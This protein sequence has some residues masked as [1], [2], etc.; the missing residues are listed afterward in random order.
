MRKT[1][2]TALLETMSLPPDHKHFFRFT[3]PN[4]FFAIAFLLMLGI[5]NGS[6]AQVVV[7]RVYPTRVTEGVTVTIE[8]SGFD[9]AT[10]NS[11]SFILGGMDAR[12][13]QLFD[14]NL[15]TFEIGRNATTL[16]VDPTQADP[17]NDI[18][19]QLQLNGVGVQIGGQPVF[20]DYIAPKAM[21]HAV[22]NF[23][24]RIPFPLDQRVTEIYTDYGGVKTYQ[25]GDEFTRGSDINSTVFGR[26]EF[27][28]LEFDANPSGVLLETGGRGRGMFIGFNSSGQFVARGGDGRTVNPA[29][30]SG[31]ARLVLDRSIFAGKTG[32]LLVTLDPAN[33][34]LYLE[35]D[36]NNDGSLDYFNTIFATAG[37]LGYDAFREWSGGNQGFVG[38][39]NGNIAGSEISGVADFNGVIGSMTFRN[40]RE[41][42]IAWRSS[43]GTYTGQPSGQRPANPIIPDNYHDL[44]GFKYKGIVYSTGANDELLELFLDD[45]IVDSGGNP[46]PGKYVRQR[47]KAYSTNGVQNT[48][49]SQHHIFTGEFVDGIE[50]EGPFDFINNPTDVNDPNYEQ[51]FENIKGLSMFDVLVDGKNGLNIGSGINNLN[52]STSIQFFSGNAVDGKAGDEIPDLLVPN[53]AEAGGT[54]VYYYADRDGNVIGR[55]ISIRINN[56]DSNNPPLSHWQNDQYRVQ[57]PGISFASARPIERIYGI[58]QERPMRLIA[59]QLED[60]GISDGPGD[61]FWK[62][63]SIETI[64]AGAGGTADIPFLAYNG[65]TFQIRSPIVT[66]RPTPRSVCAVPSNIDVNL[67]VEASVDGGFTGDSRETLRF[68][69]FKF[70]EDLNNDQTGVTSSDIDINNIDASDIGL[71]RIRISNFYGTTIVEVPISEG[72]SPA[73]WDGSNWVFLE[74]FVAAGGPNPGGLLKEVADP[75]RRLIFSEDYSINGSVLEGCDCIVPAGSVVTMSNEGT[76]KLYGEITLNPEEPTFDNDGVQNGTLPRGQIIINDGSSLVQTKDIDVNDNVGEILM[77]RDSEDHEDRDFVYWS[78]PVDGFDIDDLGGNTASYF[79]DTRAPNPNGTEGFW[80]AHNGIMEQGKG[81]IAQVPFSTP[82]FTTSFEGLPNNGLIVVPVDKTLDI[83]D[84]SMATLPVED[85]HYNLLGNPYPSAIDAIA[86]LTHPANSRLDGTLYVWDSSASTLAAGNTSP[87]YQD[88]VV[89]YS[90]AY[91]VYNALGSVPAT[92]FSGNIAAGQAFFVKVDDG[93]SAGDVEFRNTMRVRS[94]G[95]IVPNNEFFRNGGQSASSVANQEKHL[96]WLNLVNE[97]NAASSTLIGYAEGATNGKDRLYDAFANISGAQF[98]IYSVM[99][100]GPMSIQGRAL[101]FDTQDQVALG[102]NIPAPGIYRIGIDQIEGDLFADPELPL[103]LEDSYTG[104][105][106][107]LRKAPYS[108]NIQVGGAYED[109]FILRYTSS[110]LTVKESELSKTYA[111]IRDGKLSV[112]S[113]GMISEVAVYDITGKR[114]LQ[115]EAQ[116][117]TAVEADFNKAR[118]AYIAVITLSDNSTARIKLIH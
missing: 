81:Y 32:R 24:G 6:Q 16:N 92:T 113:Q 44:L 2:Q 98:S 84:I 72:G 35:W 49:V 20:I 101:P 95:A 10:R 52:R 41:E 26:W 82:S 83:T 66:K 114:V 46:I 13:K 58:E 118:G 71:Y 60:F 42:R 99:E 74:G 103:I 111:F 5:N 104:T 36:E 11:I 31:C 67:L 77:Y 34:E 75:D 62:L 90:D 93:A 70:N 14:D 23:E 85:R 88:F 64:N 87:F 109:R 89:A 106:H 54:D 53:M 55:P 69:W 15:M 18:S 117:S 107:D 97:G 57:F 8:G 112:Q 63:V 56:S 38:R 51:G 28:N 108:F 73:F 43:Q 37:F 116:N 86:F 68:E 50:R 79:W 17:V 65:E 100:E 61:P 115:L 105:L 91:I 110:R 48:T 1:T 78:S 59:F 4:S 76:L 33:G 29:N 40:S 9:N 39:S 27:F 47:Y 3:K 22:N 30:P 96:L 7:D 80:I 94:G 102:V 45:E 25:D 21:I 12:N 19:R